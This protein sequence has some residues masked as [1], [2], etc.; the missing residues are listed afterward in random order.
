MKNK[1]AKQNMK[2]SKIQKHIP[3]IIIAC[4]VLITGAILFFSSDDVDKVK[5]SREA[6]V[7][8]FTGA[9]VEDIEPNGNIVEM[10]MTASEGEVE[11]LKK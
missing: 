4:A 9:Y 8:E 3:V 11:I 7:S 6:F 5:V 2:F 10:D 1:N